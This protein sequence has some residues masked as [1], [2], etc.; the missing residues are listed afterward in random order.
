MGELTRVKSLAQQREQ[1]G[2]EGRGNSRAERTDIDLA[3]D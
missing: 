1:Q 2:R 3:E